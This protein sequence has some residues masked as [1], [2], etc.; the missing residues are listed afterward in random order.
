[1]DLDKFKIHNK[2]NE[3]DAFQVHQSSK[4][5]RSYRQQQRNF[6]P[7]TIWYLVCHVPHVIMNTNSGPSILIMAASNQLILSF[8]IYN[9]MI[10]RVFYLHVCDLLRFKNGSIVVAVLL[11]KTMLEALSSLIIGNNKKSMNVKNNTVRQIVNGERV[12][13]YTNITINDASGS[14]QGNKRTRRSAATSRINRSHTGVVVPSSRFL[15]IH[16][17]PLLP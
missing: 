6:W 1:M 9:W 3:L 10:W 16:V 5:C 17:C 8:I 13:Y 12:W 2:S 11:V 14:H 4:F 7:T 15:V